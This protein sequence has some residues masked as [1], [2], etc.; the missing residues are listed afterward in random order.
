MSDEDPV[1]DLDVA[2]LIL[3]GEHCR[4]ENI[5]VKT[6]TCLEDE[7]FVVKTG[8]GEELVKR[9][10]G[11][12]VGAHMRDLVKMKQEH[13]GLFEGLEVYTQPSAVVDSLVTK[14]SMESMQRRHGATV[15]MRDMC[16][17]GGCSVAGES[18]AFSC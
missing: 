17:G 4:L 8:S 1:G 12:S 7:E 10:K 6:K 5:C 16:G 2:L 18:L 3:P 15:W 13:P 11:Q 9:K 14:W